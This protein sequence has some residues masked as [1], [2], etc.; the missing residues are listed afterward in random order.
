MDMIRN[1]IM[2]MHVNFSTIT[3]LF[4]KPCPLFTMIAAVIQWMIQIIML[5]NNMTQ[6]ISI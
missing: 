4:F 5:F 6:E 1:N 3:L 2:Y